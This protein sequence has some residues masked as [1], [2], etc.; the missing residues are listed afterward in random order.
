M[1]DASGLSTSQ[2]F[3]E[4]ESRLSYDLLCKFTSE[5]LED[6]KAKFEYFKK[7]NSNKTYS[8]AEKGKALESLV[9]SLLSLSGGLFNVIENLHSSTNEIDQLVSLKKEKQFL[10]DIRK[11]ETVSAF[12]KYERFICECKNYGKTV[13][14][15]YVGKLIGLMTTHNVKFAILFS[16]HGIT[17][18]AG[19]W[20]D[21]E[22][23][24][25]K[26][27]LSRENESDRP[28]IIDFNCKDFEH[29]LNGGNFLE[30]I[31]SKIDALRFDTDYRNF[32]KK[33]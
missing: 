10:T 19:S 9:T 33:K 3:S 16:Y 13:G 1:T 26:Y 15:T 2:L 18:K 12:K 27:Y 30:I 11:D 22:G 21:S 23:L 5:Q 28:C 25:K 24:I 32:L 4:I 31:D 20:K 17:G 29:I 6:Y 8:T 7:T 14:V